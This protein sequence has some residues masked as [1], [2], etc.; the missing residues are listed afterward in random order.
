MVHSF[1]A[2]SLQ[3]ENETEV[4]SL[5]HFLIM[6]YPPMYT[7]IYIQ[8]TPSYWSFI[9]HLKQEHPWPHNYR[10]IY[11][12]KLRSI[13]TSSQ[14][15]CLMITFFSMIDRINVMYIVLYTCSSHGNTQRE[16]W[17]SKL[18]HTITASMHEHIYSTQN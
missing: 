9:G 3:K 4:E 8:T 7:A 6:S 5:M 16:G 15:I 2:F 18:G 12:Y 1:P 13:P 14:V 10:L 11:I 17:H